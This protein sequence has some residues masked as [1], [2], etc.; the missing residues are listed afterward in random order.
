[1]SKPHKSATL[2]AVAYMLANPKTKQA[3]CALHF[4]VH[5]VTLG[6]ALKKHRARCEV[7]G[8][9]IKRF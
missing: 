6:N 1:M 4:G 2:Q 3:W 8:Q 5:R 7:C 9:S